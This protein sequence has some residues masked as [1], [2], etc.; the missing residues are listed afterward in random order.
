MTNSRDAHF[1]S[2]WRLLVGIPPEEVDREPI[3]VSANEK[4]I[5]RIFILDRDVCRGRNVRVAILLTQ[6]TAHAGLIS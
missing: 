4:L 3:E 5:Q 1:I 6:Q 2:R